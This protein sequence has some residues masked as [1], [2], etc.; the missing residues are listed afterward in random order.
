MAYNERRYDFGLRGYS[1]T[2][3]R[4]MAGPRQPQGQASRSGG[5]A[6][7]R[8]WNSGTRTPRVT[9]RYNRD[10][11]AYDRDFDYGARGE[12]NYP[13]TF[14]PFAGDRPLDI[15][16]E[17]DYR[18]PYTTIS[19]TRTFRGAPEPMRYGRDFNPYERD[20]RRR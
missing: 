5:G 2:T 6:D 7:R 3:R 19:G 11:V 13:R 16:D 8:D 15:G 1:D 18:R 17:R 4:R 12:D 10:Y 9:A 20:Y 14:N